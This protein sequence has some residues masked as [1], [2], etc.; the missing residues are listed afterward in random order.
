[1]KKN[2]LIYDDDQEILLLCKAILSKYNFVVE[3]LSTCENILTD[4]QKFNPHV[5]LMDLWIPQI[6][7]EK[8]IEIIKQNETTKQTPVLIFSANADIKEI[9]EKVNADGYIEKPFTI[10][11]FIETIQKHLG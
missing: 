11:T 2:I 6:G 5:I 10:S 4:I 8:A 7:G 9:S 1:M 3:T